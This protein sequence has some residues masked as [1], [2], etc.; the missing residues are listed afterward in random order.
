VKV[1]IVGAGEVGYHI[2]M[3]LSRENIDVVVVDSNKDNLR[4]VGNELDVAMIEGHGGS[5][6]VMKE[7]GLDK[8]DILLAVTNSDETNMI[9][10]LIAKA[11]FRVRRKIARIRDAE[12][13]NNSTL[14]NK[15]NLDIDP[16]ISPELESARAIA[17]LVKV[18]LATVVEDFEDGIIKVI[19]YKIPPDSYLVGTNLKDLNVKLGFRFLIGIIQRDN[20]VIIPTGKDRLEGNDIIYFPVMK[21]L[22]E[23]TMSFVTGERVKPVR[24]VMIA[25]GG[26]VGYNVALMLEEKDINVK[27][28]EKDLDRCKFLS[29]SL[30]NAT[31]LH[32]DGT[33]QTLLE[34]EN[35]GAMEVFAALSNNEELN[36]MASLL[37]KRSGVQRVI[38]LVNRTDYISLANGLGIESV[39]SPRLITASSILRYVRMGEILSLT[40]IAEDRAEI[41]EAGLKDGAILGGT[42]LMDAKLPKGALI[43][44]IIRGED[45]IIPS[46]ED[47]IHEGDRIIVFALRE[48]IK[49]VEKLI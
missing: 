31:I 8:A 17:R 2:A 32:G 4:R 37:A 9:A 48:A 39:L 28:I 38:T 6:S 35:V 47:V 46:G 16:A 44:A 20:T 41:L 36:I 14:L 43:G 13:L 26:R 45:V 18:P 5:P 19:G 21:G 24:D 49:A 29:K 3:F 27:I 40:A 7:A 11:L 42:R 30:R 15:H 33:D 1:I 23:E 25:G 12:Y 34:E 10:C 22:V